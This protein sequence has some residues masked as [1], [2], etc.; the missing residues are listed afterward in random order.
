MAEAILAKKSTL[1]VG[2]DPAL[3][4]IP[5]AL[6]RKYRRRV[7]TLDGTQAVALCFEEFCR[8]IV[9]AVADVAVAVKPQAAFFEQYGGAGWSALRGVIE[10]A[11]E[12]ELI[13]ILDAKR[14][15]IASTAVAYARAVFDGAPGFDG[16]VLG[17]NAD[18]VT[19]NPYLGADSLQPFLDYCQRGKGAFILARTSNPGARDLQEKEIDGRPFFLNVAD[20]IERVGRSYVGEHGYSDVGAVVGATAPE[21]LSALRAAL[22]RSF[23][24]VPGMGAQGGAVENL[25]GIADG[26][27]LGFIASA[28]RSIIYAWQKTGDDYRSAAA[29]AAKELR[30]RLVGVR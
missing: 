11:R 18:A 2:L 3:E 26:A 13:V 24:L 17:L 7:A 5:P 12:H 30:E 4:Q 14:G 21:A 28:S 20:L 23:F 25:T 10:Y 19:L 29:Q 1:C 8:G 6:V 15:D 9:D 27:G 16:D 22:P